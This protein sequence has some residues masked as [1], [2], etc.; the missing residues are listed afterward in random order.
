MLLDVSEIFTASTI[1]DA[2]Q[3]F[4]TEK[5]KFARVE[6]AAIVRELP[7]ARP[8]RGGSKEQSNGHTQ[9]ICRLSRAC[10]CDVKSQNPIG[11]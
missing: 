8:S 10:W 3:V 9:M 1:S 5:M 7:V 2:F 4:Q 6:P 11:F